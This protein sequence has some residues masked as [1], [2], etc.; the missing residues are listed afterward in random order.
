MV[1]P[2]TKAYEWKCQKCDW[3]TVRAKRDFKIGFFDLFKKCPKCKS[4][5]TITRKPNLK[6]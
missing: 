4:K 6:M 3:H 5:I 2:G 1:I